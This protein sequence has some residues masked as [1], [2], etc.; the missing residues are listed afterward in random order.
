MKY[1][2]R[3][4]A[5]SVFVEVVD[6]GSLSAAS[7]KLKMPLPT[8]SRKV[9]QLEAHLKARLLNR[10][11]RKL[12]LTDAGRSFLLSCKSILENVREAERAAS[13]EYTAPTGELVIT[14]PIVLGRLHVLPIATEFLKAYP[15][16]QARLVLGDASL[17]LL[18]N[19]IDIAV[20]IGELPGSNL[21]A[22]R[23]GT[24]KTVVCA[25]P[26]YLS[27]RGTPKRP[28]DLA[29][30]ECI[31]FTGLTSPDVWTFRTRRADLAV[32]VRSRLVV[33]T[34]EAAIDA[35]IQGAGVTR[36]LSYQV[37]SAL[38]AGKLITALEN[39][40][41]APVPVSLVYTSQRLLPLKVRAFLEY[42]SPRLR[43]VLGA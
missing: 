17:D 6:A 16:V 42:A 9:T 34:A 38:R 12:V 20:R 24:I 7:R 8:V 32:P 39:Y 43:K 3:F 27:R 22:T 5:M 21:I 28:Q 18:E 33:N 40:E 37:E 26:D 41:S 30:H 29:D 14:A 11:T 19:H 31:S 35:A 15:D 13:G 25:S 23:V 10:S 2:D 1:M 4:E 36:V